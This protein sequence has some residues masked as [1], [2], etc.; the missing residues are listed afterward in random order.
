MNWKELR[1][2]SNYQILTQIAYLDLKRKLENWLILE[3]IF[4][5]WKTVKIS[6]ND[7]IR[8]E[9]WFTNVFLMNGTELRSFSHF[10]NL[11][12]IAYPEFSRILQID[13]FWSFSSL[14]VK[15]WKSVKMIKFKGLQVFCWGMEQN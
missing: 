13:K 12:K 4:I 11:T 1:R 6:Q 8:M 2:F 10:Q 14:T 5:H 3:F 9:T 15:L 7:Q